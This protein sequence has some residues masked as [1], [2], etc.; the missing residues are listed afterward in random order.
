MDDSFHSVNDKLKLYV[1]NHLR[2]NFF[3]KYQRNINK[4]LVFEYLYLII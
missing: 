3:S 1:L 2:I 4:I